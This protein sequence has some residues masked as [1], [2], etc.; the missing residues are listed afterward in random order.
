M[1]RSGEKYVG[2]SQRFWIV[3]GICYD[4]VHVGIDG[5]TEVRPISLGPGFYE[6]LHSLRGEFE[7]HVEY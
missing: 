1:R 6:G 7:G 2:S 5:T 3:H 4:P